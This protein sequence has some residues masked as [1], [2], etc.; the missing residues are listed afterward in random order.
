MGYDEFWC[1]AG[2]EREKQWIDQHQ[3]DWAEIDVLLPV[4]EAL[5]DAVADVAV[6]VSAT[7]VDRGGTFEIPYPYMRL[8]SL[9][10]QYWSQAK[11]IDYPIQYEGCRDR[12]PSP[13][14]PEG[15][16]D[17]PLGTPMP[18][19]SVTST[20]DDDDIHLLP[21]PGGLFPQYPFEPANNTV[22]HEDQ[23]LPSGQAFQTELVVD[24]YQVSHRGTTTFN[25]IPTY[26]IPAGVALTATSEIQL[27]V[28]AK[29]TDPNTPQVFTETLS[30][31][32]GSITVEDDF[33]ITY[34][35]HAGVSQDLSP[36][37]NPAGQVYRYDGLDD[38]DVAVVVVDVPPG[39]G[40][41]TVTHTLVEAP[42]GVR[43]TDSLPVLIGDRSHAPDPTTGAWSLDGPL[44]VDF[45]TTTRIDIENLLVDPDGDALHIFDVQPTGA[46]DAK[47]YDDGKFS[48]P[49]GQIQRATEHGPLPSFSSGLFSDTRGFANTATVTTWQNV[50]TRNLY[51][52]LT[53]ADTITP[54][55][56]T[57]EYPR[58]AIYQHGTTIDFQTDLTPSDVN[59][60]LASGT[61]WNPNP[62]GAAYLDVLVDSGRV[63]D[64]GNAIIRT[65]KIEVA[66]APTRSTALHV[67]PVSQPTRVY[68][69]AVTPN[70]LE[71]DSGSPDTRWSVSAQTAMPDR[72]YQS[73]GGVPVDLVTGSYL[74]HHDLILDGSG[75]N[76]ELSIP[77]LVYDSS[78]VQVDGIQTPVVQV[79]IEP[80]PGMTSSTLVDA[81]LTWYDHLNDDNQP[82]TPF[83]REVVSSGTFDLDWNNG[84]QVIALAVDDAPK[85]TG[86]YSWKIDIAIGETT[87][88]N[89]G[90]T[91]VVVNQ[92]VTAA[93]FLPASP[94]AWDDTAIFGDGWSLAGV[95]TITLD[96]YDGG[97]AHSRSWNRDGFDDRLILAFPGQEPKVFEYSDLTVADR[98]L[99]L[100]LSSILPGAKSIGD[101]MANPREYGT[102]T[103]RHAADPP[104]HLQPQHP[105]KPDEL[106][107]KASDGTE[108]IFHR[109]EVEPNA[110]S[111]DKQPKYLLNRIEQ[112]GIDFDPSVI[113]SDDSVDRRGVSF[114][115]NVDGRLD[116]IIASDG[117]EVTLHYDASGHVDQLLHSS[118]QITS[119]VVDGNGDLT[120]VDHQNQ[121]NSSSSLTVTPRVRQF[122]YSDHLL[123]TTQWT[124][125]GGNPTVKTEFKTNRSGVSK[126][127]GLSQVI[128]GDSTTEI[129]GRLVY[130]VIP[131]TLPGLVDLPAQTAGIPLAPLTGH[132]T[133][134]AG[135]QK[136]VGGAEVTTTGDHDQAYKFDIEGR[137]E[138][139]QTRFAGQTINSQAW[140]Y[141]AIGNVKE[142]TDVDDSLTL[143]AYDYEIPVTADGDSLN[144][145]DSDD[146]RGNVTS[147][148]SHSGTRLFQY[149]TD[150]STLDAV[151]SLLFDR[152]L[153]SG[154]P[155][156]VTQFKYQN[157]G[158]IKE[159]RRIRG[160]G[161]GDVTKAGEDYLETWTYNTGV[162]VNAGEPS[163]R[164]LSSTDARGLTTQYE[165]YFKG[166]L[167]KSVTTGSVYSHEQTHEFSYDDLGFTNSVVL[168]DHDDLVS[169]QFIHRDATGLLLYA[170]TLDED[171]N[172]LT[173]ETLQYNADGNLIRRT[174]PVA[175]GSSQTL[176]DVHT[177]FVYNT[178]G[179][180]TSTTIADGMDYRSAY[181]GANESIGRTISHRYYADGTLR[182]TGVL[183]ADGTTMQL[184]STSYFI[185][186]INHTRWTVTDGIAGVGGAFNEKSIRTETIDELGRVL[187]EQDSLRSV[188]HTNDLADK[189]LHQPS[190]TTS[191]S[192][193]SSTR[194]QSST[195]D[196]LGRMRFNLSATQQGNVTGYDVMGLVDEIRR[197]DQPNA[198]DVFTTNA[199]GDIL[200]HTETRLTPNGTGYDTASYLT[201][202]KYDEF[203]RVRSVTDAGGG[204]NETTVD[205]AYDTL[206]KANRV[207]TTSRD[208]AITI[209][210]VDAAGR[211]IREQNELGGITQYEY[212]PAGYLTDQ[213]FTP[214]VAG[215]AT[216]HSQHHRDARGRIR[217][218]ATTTTGSGTTSTFQVFDY[219]D[220]GDETADGWNSIVFTTRSGD[221]TTPIPAADKYHAMRTRADA[222]GTVVLT[223][224]P[225]PSDTPSNSVP[226]TTYSYT[227]APQLSVETQLVSAAN[228]TVA[229]A[230]ITS[231]DAS[232]TRR[233][234]QTF[235]AFGQPHKTEVFDVHLN[236][237]GV[238]QSASWLTISENQYE[239][240]TGRLSKT[241][242]ALGNE[243][244]YTYDSLTGAVSSITKPNGE[245]TSYEYDSAGNRTRLT[246]SGAPSGEH[247]DTTWG[248]DALSRVK[249]ESIV[250]IT[251]KREWD[252]STPL[253]TVYNDRNGVDHTTTVNLTAGTIT[254]SATAGELAYNRVQTLTRSG[255]IR[256]VTESLTET[257]GGS[258]QT[259]YSS[260]IDYDPD[261]SD[262]QLVDSVDLLFGTR[263]MDYQTTTTLNGRRQAVDRVFA[264]ENS[265]NVAVDLYKDHSDY[266]QAGA[267]ASIERTIES[268]A[269]G[270]VS[271]LWSGSNGPDDKRIEYDYNVDGSR[272]QIRRYDDVT[273]P[274]SSPTATSTFAYQIGGRVNE[275]KHFTGSDAGTAIASHT[276][277]YDAAGRLT[278]Q[279][280]DYFTGAGVSLHSS[281]RAFEFDTADLLTKVTE[282]VNS[283]TPVVR[284]YTNGRSSTSS[285]WTTGADNRL[286]QDDDYDYTY[287]DEG[288]LLTRT[289]RDTNAAVRTETFR[290]DPAGRLISVTQTDAADATLNTVE[291]GYDANGLKIGRRV[292]NSS[293]AITSE[294]GTLRQGLQIVADLDLTGTDPAITA[295]YMHGTQPNE[296][297]ATDVLAGTDFKAVWS[298]TDALGSVTTNAS[299][300]S[301]AFEVVHNI[302]TEYGGDRQQLGDLS[303]A[304]LTS[305]TIWAGHHVDPLTGLV[306][307]KA[308]WY[309]PGTGRFLSNDPMGFAA[310]DANL[311]RYVGNG[312]TNATDPSGLMEPTI[313]RGGIAIAAH[314]V[315]NPS[316]SQPIGFSLSE[317]YPSGYRSTADRANFQHNY[318]G[319]PDPST[320]NETTHFG[321]NRGGIFRVNS[322]EELEPL[323][324]HTAFAG[325]PV[326]MAMYGQRLDGPGYGNVAVTAKPYM[327]WKQE[328]IIT[329]IN[330]W[331]PVS[332][333]IGEIHAGAVEGNNLRAGGGMLSIVVDVAAPGVANNI[334]GRFGDDAIRV[335]A[336]RGGFALPGGSSTGGSFGRS[337][338]V[339]DEVVDVAQSQ[340]F[341]NRARRLG[342]SDDAINALPNRLRQYG[343]SVGE[344]FTGGWADAD[345][346]LVGRWGV[347]STRNQR[348][349]HEL[350]HVLDDVANPGLFARSGQAGF[351]WRG[352]YNAERVAYTTQYGFN[353]AP[354]TAF[355]ATAQAYPIGTRIVVIGGTTYAVYERCND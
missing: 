15:D 73:V 250:G 125:V 48:V 198:K 157:D 189:P 80:P 300:T 155:D 212:D 5:N 163:G 62:G 325:D 136:L 137:L 168:R 293:N 111:T 166:Q 209:Q 99:P 50:A 193:G 307:A 196:A 320:L 144:L 183:A 332:G 251:E 40:S 23:Q 100:Q 347:L 71:R 12:L 203:G 255:A 141:D 92:S 349:M 42:V 180:I 77:G 76:S 279:Q 175:I 317:F 63:D 162:N 172:V 89:H 78:A 344:T 109:Y 37:R 3:Q 284:N 4:I 69:Q 17:P 216:V 117:A 278:Q 174:V 245:T 281:D 294:T 177:T 298:F 305:T 314:G 46:W 297:V 319:P 210:W 139:L 106:V 190:V 79:L 181:T 10:D 205:Y 143:Y 54:A 283:G 82:G 202:M 211:L 232:Q 58:P 341:I 34:T 249:E 51:F 219:F 176:T 64:N 260:D 96:R 38:F 338:Q 273:S 265:S 213:T 45:E 160:G 218:T 224:D 7:P 152:T 230:A 53:D 274:S 33:T 47:Q 299:E 55:D 351:G 134:V 353:P 282:T 225:D 228:V 244:S 256:G 94:V 167:A 328:R 257:I 261:S 61:R 98:Q 200:T 285:T 149:Q 227:Y 130:E 67:D 158:R 159:L 140:K 355:N 310:G 239:P 66:P 235:N 14:P 90:Q 330:K 237:S 268:I 114:H 16:P 246:Y 84:A 9:A 309:D 280:D 339:L 138:N 72:S 290:W 247:G 31:T 345:Q 323:M 91:P 119:L 263:S 179:L 2:S 201:T 6:S 60:S 272:S 8:I 59:S 191:V 121:V 329:S 68:E 123:A 271:P 1:I 229:G 185:D 186:P 147:I 30:S 122:T 234:R 241:K 49:I 302:T 88:T 182:Q 169:T 102:L 321:L 103:A 35:P 52:Q 70:L 331:L 154:Q 207:T 112:P 308:R 222:G 243:T 292:K 132:I 86:L 148:Q 223:Q 204:D 27:R 95:P 26:S 254:V 348:I 335:A 326:A 197:A 164:L 165:E 127:L 295:L 178:A 39:G 350:G 259:L 262:S 342:F 252:Y 238:A 21:D 156:Q 236:A 75:G 333:G 346:F 83:G 97:D 208:G 171:D 304:H 266:D 24:D 275:I 161:G 87:I 129:G 22:A 242:D 65:L 135:Y 303:A 270:G 194:S 318:V 248:Y 32:L 352:F 184:G 170:S 131:A 343:D 220:F 107:F 173:A 215:E 85:L 313:V 57:G 306:E 264:L 214:G 276:Y 151:G 41:G 13:A 287:S 18:P 29:Q 11:A 233:N 296:I 36:R 145:Y 334:I 316:T 277:G 146:Y 312:P 337:A 206:V 126:Q 240:T 195:V 187:A 311:Y 324:D 108:Y 110:T 286:T 188:T 142:H 25:P 101:G 74:V 288:Q 19:G 289:S 43:V 81:T 258:P 192:D 93:D 221:G 336:P 150:D 28:A 20:D 301:G 226:T 120:S 322:Y 56:N 199:A 104:A 115:R 118:G 340:R 269:G 153:I 128:I 124:A 354:L 327:R 217:A 253:Q 105:D 133:H 291:Y 315:N 231:T 116:K 267:L 44:Y 113:L